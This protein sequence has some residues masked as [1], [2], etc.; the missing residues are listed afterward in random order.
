VSARLR[1]DRLKWVSF[2]GKRHGFAKQRV[3]RAFSFAFFSLRQR[4]EGAK[5]NFFRISEFKLY[6][7][8]FSK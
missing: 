8:L 6:V 4:K 7:F 1:R 5:K 3:L 2:K